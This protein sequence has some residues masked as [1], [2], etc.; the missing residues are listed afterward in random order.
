MFL[1]SLRGSYLPVS[2]INCNYIFFFIVIMQN[3]QMFIQNKKTT[4]VKKR[5]KVTQISRNFL[6]NRCTN[7]IQIHPD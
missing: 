7:F 1:V 5:Q 3:K 4:H 6:S 2:V